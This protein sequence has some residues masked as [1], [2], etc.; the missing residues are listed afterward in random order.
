MFMSN[1]NGT[2]GAS[3]NCGFVKRIVAAKPADDRKP[4]R[5]KVLGLTR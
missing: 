5:Q 2:F 1:C 3:R 4:L